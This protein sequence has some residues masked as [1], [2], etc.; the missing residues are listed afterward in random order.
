[1]PV[2]RQRAPRRARRWLRMIPWPVSAV[3]TFSS[4]GM[5][6]GADRL[7]E[8]TLRGMNITPQGDALTQLTSVFQ[9]GMVALGTMFFFI[10]L[11]R[12]GHVLEKSH[13]RQA[14]MR[15]VN[16]RATLERMNWRDFEY[17][18][19]EVFRQRGY[20]VEEGAGTQDGGIDLTM[21][22]RGKTWLAQC[23]HWKGPVGVA[24]VREMAG[25]VQLNRAHGGFI[26]CS[27]GYTR[28]AKEEA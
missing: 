26:V 22:K 28:N 2:S 25:V 21:T 11:M 27:R 12:V 3:L 23:K 5:I 14:L 24:V 1:M 8:N 10:M 17:L 13:A 15:G 16:D 9:I 20:H 18:S 7:A 6:S 4:L 19:G